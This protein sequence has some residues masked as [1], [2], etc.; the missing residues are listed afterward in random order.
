MAR[1][2]PPGPHDEEDLYDDND[3]TPRPEE[4]DATDEE[5]YNG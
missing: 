5:L 2:T 3:H 1:Q 4:E